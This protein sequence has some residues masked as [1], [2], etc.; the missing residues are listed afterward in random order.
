ME[1]PKNV[2]Q[3]GE[4][5]RS[6]K[7]YVEDYVISYIRQLN[8]HACDKELAVALYG[9]RREEGGITYLFFYGAGKVNFLQRECRHLSQTQLQEIEKLRRKHFAEYVFLG[10][11]LLSGEPVEGFH[12]YEQ[13]ACRYI[14]GYAQFYEKNDSMLAYMLEER[15]EEAKPEEVDLEKYEAVRRRQEEKRAQVIPYRAAKKG[16]RST[17]RHGQGLAVAA[18]F[19]AVCA[20]GLLTLKREG[21][22]DEL[23]VTARQMLE[24][25]S[26]QQLPDAVP[27]EA[28]TAI[29]G[30]IVAEDKLTEAIRE[31]NV[32]G[33]EP[34][35]ET[36]PAASGKPS[37]EEEPATETAPAASGKPPAEEEP[38]TETAPA[39]SD[40]PSAEAESTTET[41][42]AASGKPSAEEEPTT[43]TVSEAASETSA[44]PTA[45]T[46]KRGDTLIG[47]SLQRYGTDKKVAEIC[48]LNDIENPDD[49]KIGQKIFLP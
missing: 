33:A 17:G 48:D 25:M 32:A 23:Q 45:Y 26:A 38:T 42:P 49:I 35:T 44:V 19:A 28:D 21:T 4:S 12:V 31:E 3:I 24:E 27:A 15:P 22:L 40:E 1:L 20:A 30:A 10:Y 29:V 36:A 34:T 16:N 5:D 14:T 8:R 13:E 7:I 41:A 43:E 6:C 39:A 47:I 11:R 2:T 18:A 37:A 46:I 9:V